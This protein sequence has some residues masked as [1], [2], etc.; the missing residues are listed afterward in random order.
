MKEQYESVT[1]SVFS[2]DSQPMN[3]LRQGVEMWNNRSIY[4]VWFPEL[5]FVRR[6]FRRLLHSRL[7]F[8]LMLQCWRQ[9]ARSFRPGGMA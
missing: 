4:L 2:D 7:A 9:E 3:K 6:K 5:E 1:D 8:Q